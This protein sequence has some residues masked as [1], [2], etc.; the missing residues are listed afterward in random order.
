MAQIDAGIPRIVSRRSRLLHRS[1]ERPSSS[2]NL[3]YPFGSGTTTVYFQERV[4]VLTYSINV[5]WRGV[6]P[7]CAGVTFGENVWHHQRAT[8]TTH[9]IYASCETC[10]WEGLGLP[11]QPLAPEAAAS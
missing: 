11:P 4:Q 8:P 5:D 7:A 6:C 1:T 10:G 9:R 3:G 2:S